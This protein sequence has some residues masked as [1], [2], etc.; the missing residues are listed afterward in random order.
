MRLG[1]RQRS[2]A[3]H[4]GRPP[5]DLHRAR[6]V[7]V[8]NVAEKPSVAKEVARVLSRGTAQQVCAMRPTTT[9]PTGSIVS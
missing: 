7:V 2:G 5:P 9:V 8:L 3:I 1:R 6:M 4:A